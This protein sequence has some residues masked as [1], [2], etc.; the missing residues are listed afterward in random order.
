[1]VC[2]HQL[3]LFLAKGGISPYLSPHVLVGGRNIDYEKHCQIPFGA[4]VQAN[5]ENNPRIPMHHALLMLFI[6][7]LSPTIFKE[8]MNSWTLIQADLLPD[9]MYGKYL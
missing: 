6:C 5:Q 8:A 7:I 2:T 1:M 3:N 4:Y 9:N